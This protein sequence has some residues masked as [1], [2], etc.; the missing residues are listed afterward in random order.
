MKERGTNVYDC[1]AEHYILF[2]VQRE[3]DVDLFTDVTKVEVK[4]REKVGDKLHLE[5]VT[6][7]NGNIPP[8][9]RKMVTPRMLTWTETGTWD[10]NAK[11][12]TYKVKPFY[13]ANVFNMG[14]SFKCHQVNENR[15]EVSYVN[16]I[17]VKMPLLGAIAEKAILAAQKQNLEDAR[18]RINAKMKDFTPVFTF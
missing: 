10:L 14:G 12:Y 5:V 16:D 2:A 7:A 18:P 3:F 9:L 6:S 1:S 13:F 11:T 4:R 15:L 17:T 8:A